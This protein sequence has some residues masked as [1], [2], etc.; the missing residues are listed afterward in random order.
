MT[1]TGKAT[2]LDFSAAN[3]YRTS[4]SLSLLFCSGIKELVKT[5]SL[6]LLNYVTRTYIIRPE[7]IYREDGARKKILL[8]VGREPSPIENQTPIDKRTSGRK[9]GPKNKHKRS[10]KISSPTHIPIS[11]LSNDLFMEESS[12][13]PHTEELSG[14][15]DAPPSLLADGLSI[16][17]HASCPEKRV[18][19]PQEYVPLTQ[20][21]VPFPEGH[22]P[23]TEELSELP[24]APSPVPEKTQ[25]FSNQYTT[26]YYEE[27][28]PASRI[29][30]TY[31][32]DVSYIQ[33]PPKGVPGEPLPS[34][35]QKNS[36]LDLPD[37]APQTPDEVEGM[38]QF[39]LAVCFQREVDGELKYL[40]ALKEPNA[41]EEDRKTMIAN[42]RVLNISPSGNVEL[43][44]AR[45]S[46]FPGQKHDNRKSDAN[47]KFKKNPSL[48]TVI[49]EAK[50]DLQARAALEE[51]ARK[52]QEEQRLAKEAAAKPAA[53]LAAARPFV[54]PISDRERRLIRIAM[55]KSNNGLDKTVTIVKDK[56]IAHDFGTLLPDLFNGAE[57]GWLNDNIVDGYMTILVDHIKAQ[58]GYKHRR[59]GPAP[60]V[61][62]FASQWYTTF[63][64][65]PNMVKRWASRKQ[66]GKEQ[67]LDA[68][69]LLF[70]I[71]SGSHWRLIA[72]RPQERVIEYLDSLYQDEAS[73]NPYICAICSY[74]QMELEELYQPNEWKI[75]RR[76]RSPKQSNASDCGVF[77][78]LNALALLRNENPKEKVD[79]RDGMEAARK[80]I[81]VTLINEQ[82]TTEFN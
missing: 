60:P 76:Q 55:R 18:P 6:K 9:S 43:A 42:D 33:S 78:V 66:L 62:N 13:A 69:L 17:Y 24:D 34:T 4:V 71:C 35:P 68:K 50:W 59:G 3:I 70:P 12:T 31:V 41:D 16:D 64:G 52:V 75:L 14:L 5:A 48:A 47:I 25:R 38:E 53:S 30:D 58:A 28:D 51:H 8:D 2:Y 15:P 40:A 29:L 32:E 21:H 82:V 65:N 27:R 37:Y 79:V 44:F 26:I 1:G 39:E 23:Y 11:V 49:A 77:T 10:S 19:Y 63:T 20:E 22:I 54:A 80:R 56:L 7:P 36:F 74:L 46:L 61:H 73:G 67:L 72:L 45:P 81:A 57:L